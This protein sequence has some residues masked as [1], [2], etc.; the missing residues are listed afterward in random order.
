MADALDG[1]ARRFNG[2]DAGGAKGDT[3]RLADQ[4]DQARDAR[5]DLARLEK[6][7]KDKEAEA[8]QQRA[9]VEGGPGV[10]AGR[11]PGAAW[12]AGRR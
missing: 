1:V 4:L 6:Q 7:I 9:R 8:T 3:R 10:R 12:V 11:T 5:D 2:A